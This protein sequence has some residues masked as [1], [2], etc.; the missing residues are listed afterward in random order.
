MDPRRRFEL[1]D[2]EVILAPSILASDTARLATGAEQCVEGGG[3]WIHVDVMDGH[4]VPNL[5]FGLP[6]IRDLREVTDLPLD[7]HL[8]VSNPARLLVE[9]IDAGASHLTVHWE[10]AVHLDRL[11]EEI[12]KKGAKAG[13]ALNPATPVEVLTDILPVLD[14]VLVMSVNPGFSGQR[15]IPYCL[16]KARRLKRMVDER[17]LEVEIA[18]DGGIELGNVAAVV[19]AGVGV[20]VVGS[21]IFGTQSPPETMREFKRAVEEMT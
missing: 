6:V 3:D 1:G 9:Y 18:M 21:A 8:M 16:E 2:L 15:L 13:V 17:D 10:A 7:V 5:T 4:F 14:Q 12:K 20:C 19:T 11:I